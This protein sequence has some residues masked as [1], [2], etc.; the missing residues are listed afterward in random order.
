MKINAVVAGG[1]TAGHIEPALAVA[2]QLKTQGVEVIALGTERGLEKNI[3]PQRGFELKLI[4]AVPIPR[5]INAEL[6][7]LPWKILKSFRQTRAI[8][9]AH[10]A[11]VVIGFGG[12]VAASAY[13]AAR[14]LGI[15]YFVHEA[16]ARAGLANKLGV[17]LGGTGFNA[18]AGSGLQGEVVGIPIRASLAEDTRAA[19]SRAYE[20]WGLDPRRKTIVVTGG[21]QG[22]RSI[23]QAVSAAAEELT[24]QGYQILHAYG[25]KNEAPVQVP[26]YVAVPYIDD[27]AAAYS[28]A[29]FMVC[30]SGAMSVAEITALGIPALYIPLPH[31]NGEQA[32]NAQ[33]VVAAGAARLMSDE[34]LSAH[35][36]IQQINETIGNEE[37]YEQMAQ[38][39]DAAGL[40]NAAAIIA[41]RMCAAVKK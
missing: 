39:A 7:K 34:Q 31:G 11:D 9:K 13:L 24:T 16:N 10:N 35:T 6:V 5:S 23:N 33:E 36:L 18:V 26:H 25:K 19:R 30:R 3:I 40:G 29:D 22:A 14:S 20:Q 32:L 4:E 27:M 37:V 41:E 2:E 1:G 38:A 17:F 28:V 15:S 8:L 12:Y 21:S